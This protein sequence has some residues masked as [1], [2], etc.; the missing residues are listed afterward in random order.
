M[1]QRNGCGFE[2][3]PSVYAKVLYTSSAPD[4][5]STCLEMLKAQSMRVIEMK[6]LFSA[7]SFPGQMRRPWMHC[8]LIEFMDCRDE[9]KKRTHPNAE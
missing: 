3:K 5:G 8:Q 4:T 6:R 7:S 1:P 9:E 2:L